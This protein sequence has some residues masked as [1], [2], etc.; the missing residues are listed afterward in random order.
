MHEEP[1]GISWKP[2]P[3]DP[4]LQPGMFLSNGMIK[5]CRWNAIYIIETMKYNMYLKKQSRDI[6]KTGNLVLDWR[7][8]S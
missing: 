3:D 7:T 1:I 4:G 8:L 5:A 6:T 2:H